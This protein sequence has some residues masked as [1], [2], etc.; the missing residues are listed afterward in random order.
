MEHTDLELMDFMLKD[1]FRDIVP[2]KIERADFAN[3][4][5]EIS[6]DQFLRV[7]R[8]VL[9]A[10]IM[11]ELEENQFMMTA[12][13]LELMI[14]YGSYSNYLDELKQKKKNEK[15]LRWLTISVGI[16]TIVTTVAALLKGCS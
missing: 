8:L 11:E 15:L 3:S 13:G 16:C 5:F 1:L 2:Q 6:D 4:G 10:G 14:M 12:K 7:K 9:T